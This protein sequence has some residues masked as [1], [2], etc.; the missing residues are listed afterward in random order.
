M[1]D[2]RV[3]RRTSDAPTP[4]TLPFRSASSVRPFAG[5]DFSSDDVLAAAV[6]A[7]SFQREIILLIL[8]SPMAAWGLNFVFGLHRLDYGHYLIASQTE[9][10]CQALG[11]AWARLEQ[12]PPP[13]GWATAVTHHPG[14][15]RWGLNGTYHRTVLFTLRWYMSSRLLDAGLNVLSLDLDG[16]VLTDIYALLKRP[17]LAEHDLVVTDVGFKRG[18]NCG[19]VY[20]NQDAARRPRNALADRRLSCP[21]ASAANAT[22][23]ARGAWRSAANW[24]AHAVVERVMLFAELDE[25]IYLGP[26]PPNTTA[27]AAAAS[28]ASSA[29]ALRRRGARR[30]PATAVFWD[31]HVWCDVLR[32]VEDDREAYPW[33]WGH[34][35]RSDVWRRRLGYS[36]E[37]FS[38]KFIRLRTS[39]A[40]RYSSPFAPPTEPHAAQFVEGTMRNRLL[41]YMP[42]CA[43]R[44]YRVWGSSPRAEAAAARAGGRGCLLPGSVMLAPPWLVSQ[45]ERPGVDWVAATPPQASYVHLVNMWRCFGVAHCYTKHNK[46]WWLRA[47]GLWDDRLDRLDAAAPPPSQPPRRGRRRGGLAAAA[48]A[49]TSAASAASSAASAASAASASA[50]SAA[51]TTRVRVLG[52]APELVEAVARRGLY[53]HLHRLLH[54]LATVASLVG[55]TAA[56]PQLPCAFFERASHLAH[57][58]RQRPPHGNASRRGISLNDVLVVGGGGS[59]SGGSGGGG[60]GDGARCLLY[61]GGLDCSE[62]RVLAPFE[63]RRLERALERGAHHAAANTVATTIMPPPPPRLRYGHDAA[64]AATPPG[65]G[66]TPLAPLA[67]TCRAARSLA[68]APLV[69]LEGFDPLGD[70]IVDAAAPLPPRDSAAFVS[71]LVASPATRR[72]LAVDCDGIAE[73]RELSRSCPFYF[74]REKGAV[75]R[76][77][78]RSVEI[79]FPEMRSPSR[80]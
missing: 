66:A 57:S 80:R 13:C 26:M 62:G 36:R 77:T 20:F 17:P 33:A 49:A 16:F 5:G 68:A 67:A 37:Q 8:T 53:V 59:G 61:P 25:L 15:Q 30:H 23:D 14:W 75:D 41:Q 42:L 52:V 24:V 34:A 58:Q 10:H 78:Q 69:L 32:S 63:L 4:T 46:R 56:L 43:P 21:A 7:R 9:Q 19:F 39:T 29:A 18:I 47:V 71:E 2:G 54:N 55:R 74:L 12:P 27:T 6:S 50:A 64:A 79:S 76:Q 48:A 72:A 45:G 40:R 65:A 1:A 28:S 70:A 51:N 22:C 44:R 35:G 73:W 11:H 3:P 38:D 31:A 60:S